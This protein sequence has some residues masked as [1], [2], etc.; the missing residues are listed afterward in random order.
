MSEQAARPYDAL[1]LP[2]K[3]RLHQACRDFEKAWRSGPAQPGGGGQPPDLA[4]F[5]HEVPA[6]ERL[7]FVQELVLL[8]LDYRRAGGY[9]FLADDYLRFHELDRSWLLAAWAGGT[10]AGGTT[11]DFAGATKETGPAG[12]LPPPAGPGAA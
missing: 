6:A 1:P 8:D 2:S 12:P 4:L 10:G 9:T 5:L 11:A 7:A 3:L